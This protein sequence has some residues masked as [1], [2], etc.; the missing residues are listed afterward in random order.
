MSDRDI[1]AEDALQVAQRALQ[2]ANELEDD[3]EEVRR[4]YEEIRSDL[5]A[6]KLRLSEIKDER[7]YSDL[8]LDEKIGI[9]REHGFRRAE[10]TTGYA[11]LDYNGVMWE[12]FE[13]EPGTK[14][15]YKLLRLAAEA[16]GFEYV[17][18]TDESN[19][20]RIDAAAA[21]RGPAFFPENKAVQEEGR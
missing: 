17:D 5:T 15:C 1:S 13:G 14:H 8:T 2:K 6:A 9:V 21:K 3:L 19:H 16:E 4:D 12:V 18:S 20:L 7:D 10:D 11:K